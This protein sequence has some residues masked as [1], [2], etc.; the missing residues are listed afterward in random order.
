MLAISKQRQG[1]LAV[2]TTIIISFIL[3]AKAA[4][5]LVGI[6]EVQSGDLLLKTSDPGQYVEAPKVATDYTTTVTGPVA[7]TVVTQQFYNPSDSFVEGVYVFPLPDNSAV[8]T[9]KIISGT[10]VIVGEVK[11]KQEARRVYEQAKADGHAAAL[12]EQQR[13]NMFIN[14]VA[15]IGPH[16]KVLVQIEYQIGRAHV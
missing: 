11:E 8:D 13:P 12:L 3:S 5:A 9:L 10:H 2:V 15:N 14:S 4:F 16:E 6:N 7:R 1:F